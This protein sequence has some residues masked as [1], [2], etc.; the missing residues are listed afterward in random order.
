MSPGGCF[1]KWRERKRE[2]ERERETEG[3]TDRQAGRQ[4]DRQADRQ[5]DRKCHDSGV[6][7]LTFSLKTSPFPP[8]LSPSLFL[9]SLSFSI[10]KKEGNT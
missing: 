9:L 5:I 10:Y 7:A 1:C 4:T 3:E 6:M 8:S 2:R